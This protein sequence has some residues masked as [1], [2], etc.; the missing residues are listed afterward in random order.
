MLMMVD[1]DVHFHVIP[2]YGADQEF[3]G[4]VYPDTGWPGPPVLAPAVT[5]DETRLVRLTAALAAAW[6]D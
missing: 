2:R 3:D 1:P 5:P 4:L 6:E